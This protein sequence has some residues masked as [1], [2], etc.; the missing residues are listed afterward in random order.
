MSTMTTQEHD[1]RAALI[2]GAACSLGRA[3]ALELMSSGVRVALSD[4]TNRSGNL[5]AMAA[6]LRAAGTVE[7]VDRDGGAP[8]RQA[9]AAFGRLDC[10]VNLLVPDP[11]IA[12]A[13]LY[14]IPLAFL[15]SVLDATDLLTSS[16]EGGHPA[17]INQCSLPSAFAGT[18]FE[19]C[20]PAIKG[21]M[22]G[23]TRTMCR[24]FGRRGITVNCLHTGL[25]D[26]PELRELVHPEVARRKVPVGRWGTPGD[27]AKLVGFLALR[28]RYWTGQSIIVDGGLTS[29]I[30]GT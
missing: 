9:H 19:D 4:R 26:M 15:A 10:I 22:A 29:G 2:E 23:I 7:I 21:A 8:A 28:N 5:P 14:Q 16:G 18:R 1:G 24:R 11:M 27:V 13:D 30:T 17:V 20:M 25:I 6:E 3:I 12:P